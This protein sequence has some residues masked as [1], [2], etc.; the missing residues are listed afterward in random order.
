MRTP[1]QGYKTIAE[2]VLGGAQ[3]QRKSL[4]SGECQ[5]VEQSRPALGHKSFEGRSSLSSSPCSA[6][7]APPVVPGT[8]RTRRG[9]LPLDSRCRFGGS[10]PTDDK[11]GPL[12]GY[13]PRPGAPDESTCRPKDGPTPRCPPWDRTHGPHQLGGSLR[14]RGRCTSRWEDGAGTPPRAALSP[15]LC[16]GP[17]SIAGKGEVRL[18]ISPK[19]GSFYRIR[20][21]RLD[22][23]E[24]A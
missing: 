16:A 21:K 17:R 13:S 24:Q 7:A 3:T 14:H 23:W 15:G 20:L 8:A 18:S 5:V 19:S 9:H 4:P 12:A 1:T 10:W 22:S 11:L 6:A 2:N